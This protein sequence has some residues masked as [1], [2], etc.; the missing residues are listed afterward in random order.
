MMTTSSFTIS[1][2]LGHVYCETKRRRQARI[3]TYF[4]YT[5]KPG[6]ADESDA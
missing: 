1:S 6:S 4:D 2:R 5:R 3:N